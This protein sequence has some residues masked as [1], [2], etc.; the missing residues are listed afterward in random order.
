MDFQAQPTATALQRDYRLSK[1]RVRP[2]DFKVRL[3]AERR[4]THVQVNPVLKQKLH[5]ALYLYYFTM[6]YWYV[7]QVGTGTLFHDYKTL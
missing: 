5:K 7:S 1:H 2:C 6:V 4:R 3:R